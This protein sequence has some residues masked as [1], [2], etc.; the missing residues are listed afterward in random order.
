MW[1]ISIISKVYLFNTYRKQ[2]GEPVQAKAVQQQKAP[3]QKEKAGR[4]SE[5]AAESFTP[6]EKTTARIIE[7]NRYIDN[8]QDSDELVETV[9]DALSEIDTVLQEMRSLSVK[10]AA[11]KKSPY[12]Q[13]LTQKAIDDYVAEIELIVGRTE[14]KAAE[15]QNSPLPGPRRTIF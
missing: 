11:E 3:D 8:N 2:N 14:S 7:L 6:A 5:P 1:A 4:S 13:N 10:T 9:K 15:L 12:Q